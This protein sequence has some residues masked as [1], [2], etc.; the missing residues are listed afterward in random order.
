MIIQSLQEWS[1]DISVSHQSI[2]KDHCQKLASALSNRTNLSYEEQLIP[3]SFIQLLFSHNFTLN[4]LKTFPECTAVLTHLITHTNQSETGLSFQTAN[5]L[6]SPSKH[7]KSLITFVIL[8]AFVSF[9]S[10]IG[11]I[12]LVKVLYSK[13]HHW[14]QT[15]RIVTCLALSKEKAKE[16]ISDFFFC[17]SR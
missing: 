3:T 4:S 11:N 14:N 6:L 7:S 13:R 2:I 15:D 5:D 9:I 8:I 1:D 10:I 17:S 16:F 12:C